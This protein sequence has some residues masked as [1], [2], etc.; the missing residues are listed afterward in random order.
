VRMGQRVGKQD[1][2]GGRSYTAK[3]EQGIKK[4]EDRDE[5]VATTQDV[6]TFPLGKTT[7]MT[8]GSVESF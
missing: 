6:G 3:P 2:L 7:L 1:K 8:P 4:E 5:E